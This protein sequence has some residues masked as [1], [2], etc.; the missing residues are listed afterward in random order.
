[1]VREEELL[2]KAVVRFNSKLFGL[3][4]GLLCGIGLFLTTNF[5]VLKGGSQVGAHLGLLCQFFPGYRV[6]FLGSLVGFVY[7]GVVGF[8]V[9][10]VLGA[11]YNKVARV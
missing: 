2:E 10:S 8:V 1:M 11:V 3:V 7:A 9:G 5:L 6:T 4:L